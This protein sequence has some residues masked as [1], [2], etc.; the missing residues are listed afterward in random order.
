MELSFGELVE[1]AKYIS[2]NRTSKAEEE[3]H[4]Y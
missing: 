3:K 4:F 1:Q 2:I